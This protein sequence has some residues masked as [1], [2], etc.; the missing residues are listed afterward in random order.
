MHEKLGIF[1][2]FQVLQGSRAQFRIPSK[3][4]S[5]NQEFRINCVATPRYLHNQ[6]VDSTYSTLN[7]KRILQICVKIDSVKQYNKE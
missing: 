7:K 4:F 1:I 3:H 2:N 6:K 5:R